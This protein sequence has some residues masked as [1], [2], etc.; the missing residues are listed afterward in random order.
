M[1]QQCLNVKQIQMTGIFD[2]GENVKKKNHPSS[3]S[4]KNIHLKSSVY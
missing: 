1:S 3:V 4:V 2:S